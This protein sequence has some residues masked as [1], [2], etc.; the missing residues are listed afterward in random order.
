MHL[1]EVNVVCLQPCNSAEVRAGQIPQSPVKV[2]GCPSA[3][4]GHLL[5]GLA[6][7]MHILP[8]ACH[9]VSGHVVHPWCSVFALCSESLRYAW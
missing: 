3:A 6:V 9:T 7:A 1:D 8:C 2:K 4:L 5:S